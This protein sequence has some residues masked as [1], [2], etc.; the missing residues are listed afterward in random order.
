MIKV[1]PSIS[2]TNGKV[3]KLGSGDFENA[4]LF[5]KDP[6]YLAQYFE[7]NGADWLHLVDL[8]GANENGNTNTHILQ[9]IAGHTN[10][11]I[12]FS[13]GVRTDGSV[14]IALEA[15]AKTVTVATVAATNPS[16][17][18]DWII[19]FGRNRL[20][21]GADVVGK[22]VVSRGW[23]NQ[24]GINLWDH[25]T[26]YRD[27]SIQF[28]KITDTKRDGVLEGPNFDL[29][30]EAVERFPDMHIVASGGVRSIA[31]IEKLNEIGVWSVIVARAFYED[32]IQ[33]ADLRPFLSVPV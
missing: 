29:Y 21:L 14:N 23:H 5:D 1:I 19:T 30:K 20:V 28:V 10:M 32:K 8:D 25:I 22:E 4:K 15:G 31:D 17:F 11:K 13:G 24:T 33:M 9:I 3:A 12:N 6:L 26:Y 7:D 18:M 27:R 2:L 16:L